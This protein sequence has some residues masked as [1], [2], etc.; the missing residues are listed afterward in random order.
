MDDIYRLAD[1]IIINRIGCNQKANR[2]KQNITQQ[3]LAGATDVF[4]SSLLLHFKCKGT[5]NSNEANTWSF[6]VNNFFLQEF[7]TN[8]LVGFY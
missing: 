6:C 5:L 2:L 7:I 1:T 4:L 3:S 8:S